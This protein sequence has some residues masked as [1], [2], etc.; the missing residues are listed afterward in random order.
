MGMVVYDIGDEGIGEPGNLR[1]IYS[2]L[3]EQVLPEP[4]KRSDKDLFTGRIGTGYRG[5]HYGW[6]LYKIGEG[7]I[8]VLEYTDSWD[9][10]V[11]GSNPPQPQD[12]SLSQLRISLVHD[13]VLE[14]RIVKI[15]RECGEPFRKSTSE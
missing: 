11:R 6:E 13:N 14:K 1:K 2:L 5:N 7:K 9:G 3:R 15:V 8:A 4:I 12:A 10:I